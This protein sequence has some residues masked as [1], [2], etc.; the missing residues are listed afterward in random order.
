MVRALFANVEIN[1]VNEGADPA[2]LGKCLRK[3]SSQAIGY[4]AFYS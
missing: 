1:R 4:A 3:M 2:P